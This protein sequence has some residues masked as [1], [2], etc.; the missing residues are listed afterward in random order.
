MW[1]AP[2]SRYSP[3][4]AGS[5]PVRPLRVFAGWCTCGPATAAADRAVT[6][7]AV[8]WLVLPPLILIAASLLK[9]VYFSRYL[10]YCLP[11]VAL[12]AGAGTRRP[13]PPGADRRPC[14]GRGARR[15]DATSDAGAGGRHADGGPVPER[16]PQTRRCHRLPRIV[17]P[18]VVPR[19]PVRVRPASRHQ[20]GPDPRRG[21]PPVREHRGAAG[22]RAAR[23]ER[24]QKSGSCRCR[25]STRAPTSRQGSG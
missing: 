19:L 11:A 10:T 6:W 3:C 15:A 2:L 16:P 14:P 22:P 12:L 17:H 23:A 1:A 8:P 21:R 4:S 9:P 20:H 5:M 13:A 18:A 25:A 24:P 7:L